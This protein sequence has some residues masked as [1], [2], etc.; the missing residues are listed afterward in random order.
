MISC[1][2]KRQLQ[3]RFVFTCLSE[4]LSKMWCSGGKLGI[5]LV[6]SDEVL[7]NTKALPFL[8]ILV[9]LFVAKKPLHIEQ[10]TSIGAYM[11]MQQVATRLYP[12]TVLLT[13]CFS[14]T[15]GRYN[16]EINKTYKR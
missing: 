8:F 12:N 14:G 13:Y 1:E 10:Y 3:Y 16:I 2:I 7:Q 9:F 11:S 5:Q 15:Q 6:Y 4:H